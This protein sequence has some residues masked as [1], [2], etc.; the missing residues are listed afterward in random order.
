MSY[1]NRYKGQSGQATIEYVLMLVISVSLV[2]MLMTQIF[3]PME[4]FLDAYMGLYVQCLLEYGE[5]PSFGGESVVTDDS[6]CN[7]KFENFTLAGGRPPG[8]GSRGSN[9]GTDGTA[10]SD[11]SSGDSSITGG[12]AGSGYAGS[13]SRGGSSS[14]RNGRG[15]GSVGGDVAEAQGKTVEITLEGG[16]SGGYFAGR[17]SNDLVIVRKSR[18]IS[19][20]MLPESVRRK[21][22]KSKTGGKTTIVASDEG[23][24]RGQTKVLPVKAPEKKIETQDESV[25]FSIGGMFRI[26]FITAIV[27]IIVIFVG[28]QILQMSKSSGD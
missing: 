7:A 9:A 4:K 21:I 17:Q 28:G 20:E 26:L 11:G 6:E 19:G 13:A 24:G 15:G 3:K 27:L 8:P 14:I 25:E 1:L 12:S 2:I 16:G 22:D 23:F 18:T 5:L 10:E